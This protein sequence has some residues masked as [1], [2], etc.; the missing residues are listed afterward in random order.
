MNGETV[1]VVVAGQ[2]LKLPLSM[3][4]LRAL[5]KAEV[6]PMYLANIAAMR[7]IGL[8]INL[9]QALVVLSLGMIACG[10]V[11]TPETL[12]QQLRKRPGGAAEVNSAAMSYLHAFIQ[13]MPVLEA[14]APP[15]EATDS[16]KE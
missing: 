4:M 15:A 9:E 14:P 6:C 10:V 2:Q 3:T 12:W 11:T 16:P 5:G 13:D 8:A 7:G 1:T